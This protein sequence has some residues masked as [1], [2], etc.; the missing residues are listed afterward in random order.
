LSL[1]VRECLRSCVV[2]LGVILN[3]EGC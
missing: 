2:G 3:Y 1:T